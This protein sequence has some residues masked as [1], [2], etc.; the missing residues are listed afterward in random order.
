MR[1]FGRIAKTPTA[2]RGA[3]GAMRRHTPV[4]WLMIGMLSSDRLLGEELGPSSAMFA[5]R[6]SSLGPLRRDR[7][8]SATP[9]PVD[10]EVWATRGIA[11]TI[12]PAP[13]PR[14]RHKRYRRPLRRRRRARPP[15]CESRRL[16]PH[17]W[18]YAA[19]ACPIPSRPTCR[20][21]RSGRRRQRRFHG[22]SI[23]PPPAVRPRRCRAPAPDFFVR[24]MKCRAPQ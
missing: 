24:A 8:D 11:A 15:F 2:R 19:S 10:P 16:D 13:N 12:G 21:R 23:L 7:F 17:C 20:R 5:V 18:P 6:N 4:V 22:A 3:A 9:R 14:L 1:C